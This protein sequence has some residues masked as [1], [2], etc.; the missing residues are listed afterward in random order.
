MKNI[1][2]NELSLQPYAADLSEF[3]QRLKD[4]IAI[5]K[6]ANNKFKF[7]KLIFAQTLDKYQV[8]DDGKTFQECL[9]EKKANRTIVN[10]LL[11]LRKYPF[12]DDENEPQVEEY[13]TANF[14]HKD[15]TLPCDGLGI[16]YLY[17]TIAVSFLSDTF[18][19][20]TEIPILIK[21]DDTSI[22]DLEKSIF[23]ASKVEHLEETTN[24]VAWII[25][26]I[27]KD[28]ESIEDLKEMYPIY[29]F[30]NN[31]FDELMEWKRTNITTYFKLHALLKDIEINPFTGGIGKTEAL[32]N[33]SNRNSKR[34]TQEHRITYSL[35]GKDENKKI[36]ILSCKGHYDK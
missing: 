15:S 17:N 32:K 4:L 12:Y 33:I 13:I 14:S 10:L 21:S 35:E 36:I 18:W 24:L 7:K 16:A 23:H 25:H 2:F 11:G 26:T 9:F 8:L 19:E 6:I 34:I 27:Q 5:C 3:N 1:V 29:E 31:S 20:E 22:A 28:I 30:E